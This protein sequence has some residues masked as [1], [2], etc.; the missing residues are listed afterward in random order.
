VAGIYAR[1]LAIVMRINGQGRGACFDFRQGKIE[2]NHKNAGQIERT[3]VFQNV[4]NL[5]AFIPECILLA[6][7]YRLLEGTEQTIGFE[8]YFLACGIDCDILVECLR[9]NGFYI[10]DISFL[11][12][13]NIILTDKMVNK[14]SA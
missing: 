13:G 7:A 6:K 8:I 11:D 4:L 12:M 5:Y 3:V 14:E 2:F 10:L 1:F 9:E